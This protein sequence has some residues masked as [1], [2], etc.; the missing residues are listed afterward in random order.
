MGSTGIMTRDSFE[1]ILQNEVFP[2]E[3]NKLLKFYRHNMVSY[4]KDVIEDSV[5]YCAVRVNN[6]YTL[7]VVVLMIRVNREKLRTEVIYKVMDESSLP[8]YYDCPPSLIA[9]LTPVKDL[10]YPGSAEEWRQRC[11]YPNK[12]PSND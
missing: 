7:G 10:P 4:E 1:E 6:T 9:M 2:G 11:L 3:S 5:M 8:F 12:R